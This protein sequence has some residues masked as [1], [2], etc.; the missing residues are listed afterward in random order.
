MAEAVETPPRV[1]VIGDRIRIIWTDYGEDG[2]SVIAT[3]EQHAL[4]LH[5]SLALEAQL[6]RINRELLNRQS[7]E[8]EDM[9]R[10]VG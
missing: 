5:A 8:I 3:G 6:A 10:K 7:A 9:S 1:R 4:T 2:M